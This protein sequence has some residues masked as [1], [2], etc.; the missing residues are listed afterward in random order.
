MKIKIVIVKFE[1]ISKAQRIGVEDLGKV[2]F[3]DVD[4]YEITEDFYAVPF[5]RVLAFDGKKL[6]GQTGLYKREINYLNKDIILGGL[7][8]VCVLPDYRRQGIA[9][10]MVK[11]GMKSL[12]DKNCDI[13]FLSV[14]LLK[15]VYSLY[16][17]Y[18]F[19][20]ILQPFSWENIHGEI[21]TENEGGMLAKVKSERIFDHVFNSKDVFHVGKGYW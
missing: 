8:G 4:P 6:V 2:C 19:R 12:S 1:N 3:S 16:M 9:E 5:A 15:G 10:E 20:F 7:G 21:V 14:D 18:G 17:K 13:A 11:I